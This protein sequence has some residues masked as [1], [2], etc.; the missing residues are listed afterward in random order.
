M[1]G[2]KGRTSERKIAIE[3]IFDKVIL[4]SSVEEMNK[5]RSTLLKAG[6]DGKQAWTDLKAQAVRYIRDSALKPTTDESGN[7]LLDPQKLN[8]VIE[9]LDR[10]GKLEALVGKKQAQTIRDLGDLAIDIYTAPPSAGINHSNT[11]TALMK[12]MANVMTLGTAYGTSAP[13]TTI[14]MQAVNYAK[15]AETRKRIKEALKDPR[16]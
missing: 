2:K 6:P 4:R 11:A 16:K 13:T 12:V 9:S 15:G 3:E 8:K 5:L 7:K 14:I 1:L 10:T